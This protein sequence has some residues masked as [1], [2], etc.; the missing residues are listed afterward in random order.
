LPNNLENLG[1]FK[2]PK[3]LVEVYLNSITDLNKS[4]IN[5]L[6]FCLAGTHGVGKSTTVTNILKKACQKNFTTLY[7]NLGDIVSALTIASSE[8]KYF[9]RKELT[10]VDFLVCDEFDARHMGNTENAIDLFGRT[11]EYVIRTRLQNKLPMI[12]VSNSPNPIESFN[13]NIK[14]SVESLMAKLPL[15]PILGEDIRKVQG[16]N[17]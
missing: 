4:Y 7:T 14:Q 10:E 5:G 12:L 15:I 2:G 16:M 17:Q 13:G 1:D 8:D 3:N 9:A 11:L 6:S